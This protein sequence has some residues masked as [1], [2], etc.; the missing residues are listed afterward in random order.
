MS[1]TLTVANVLT[2]PNITNGP[3]PASA[4]ATF[5]YSF[6]Y[7]ASGYPNP[8]FTL[9]N[10]SLPPGLALSTSGV[11]SG[12][13]D[14][15][16]R[17]LRHGHAGN[18][19]SPDATQAFT[20][21]VQMPVAPAITNGPSPTT[22]AIGSAYNFTY[23]ATGLPTPSFSVTSGS[24]PPGLALIHRGTISGAPTQTGLYTG[25]SAQQ[26]VTARPQRKTFPSACSGAA[27]TSS[28]LM[29]PI[30]LNNSLSFTFTATG[31]PAP[32]FSVTSGSLP[33]GMT[34]ST[35][36]VLS[37]APTQTGVTREP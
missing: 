19:I 7:T 15:A 32:T 29:I 5:A 21:T 2:A 36:G 37:G 35:G 28:P 25:R 20:I 3:P 14:P 34:L 6:T 1:F 33:P 18:Q 16:G 9:L 11:L 13:S 23:A 24:L 12:H 27:F 4:T 30:A 10:G 26:T 22:G 8:T 31:F 17:L